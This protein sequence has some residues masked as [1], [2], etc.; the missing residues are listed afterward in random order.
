MTEPVLTLFST[1]K[2]FTNRHIAMI[3]RNA[4]RSWKQM[5]KKVE[6]V[7]IGEEEGVRSTAR[8]LDVRLV[9][10]VRRN[11]KGTP[12]VSSIFELARSVNNS[13][14]MG[15]INTDVIVFSDF[16]EICKKTAEQAERFVLAGQRWD[17]KVERPIRFQIGWESTLKKDIEDHGRRHPPAGSDYFVF[18]RACYASIP[19]FAIGRAGWDNWMIF[20][21]RWEH[22]KMIDASDAIT[23]VH[24]DHDYSHLPNGIIHHRQAETL[25]NIKI[26][27]GRFAVYTLCDANY[28]LMNNRILPRKI[29][30]SRLIREISLFPSVSLKSPLLGKLF[31]FLF[32]LQKVKRDIQKDKNIK[33]HN[34]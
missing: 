6:V 20:K 1:P 28:Y 23:V 32:N 7:L 14:L 27:G 11:K 10:D 9:A 5:G 19:D 16:L 15:F 25:E 22:W 8:E 24:Q 2:P 31:Y 3:Q 26:M 12:L 13:P 18:P 29:N 30:R 17:L 34:P 4:I 21:A 33:A